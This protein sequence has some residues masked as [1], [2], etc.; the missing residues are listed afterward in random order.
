MTTVGDEGG[1]DQRDIEEPP[2][3]SAC[4]PR[5]GLKI[6]SFRIRCKVTGES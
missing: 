3:L 4:S 2:A 6:D 1:S 5:T